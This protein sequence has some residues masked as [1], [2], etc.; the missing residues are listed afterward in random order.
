MNNLSDLSALTGYKTYSPAEIKSRQTRKYRL[1]L[2]SDSK[3]FQ[4]S[5]VDET[6][7][8]MKLNS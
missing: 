4:L 6:A 5:K 1:S 2:G 3:V 7:R 8:V